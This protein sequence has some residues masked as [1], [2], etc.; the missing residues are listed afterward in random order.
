ML[1]ISNNSIRG[2]VHADRYVSFRMTSSLRIARLFKRFIIIF[3]ILS[4][5]AM[6]MPW[7]QNVQ[8]F[9]KITALR[10]ESRPQTLQS[11]IP[12]RI[13]RWFVREGD[14]VK[15]GD[16]LA[17]IGEVK[18]EY[19]DPNMIARLQEEL[20]S[21]EQ[22]AESYGQKVVAQRQQVTA[23]R[24]NL[25]VKLKQTRLKIKSDSTDVIAAEINFNNSYKQYMRAD[26]LY[27]EGIKS[28]F[29]VEQRLSKY[30]QSNAYLVTAKNKYT[31]SRQELD[32][33][34]ADY[35]EKISKA[36]SEMFSAESARQASLGDVAK[37]RNKIASVETR[38]GY[39]Y[40][41]SPQ[42]AMVTKTIVTGIGENIK[43]GEAIVE[44]LPLDY[45]IA[46]EI[47]VRPVDLPLV[48]IGNQARL[49]FDGWP[50]IVFSGWP[51]TS[52]GT[53]SA[54]VVAVDNVLSSEGGGYRILL[55][56]DDENRA[57]PE[58]LR[59]GSGVRSIMLL[60]DVPVWYELWRQL[61]GFP[62]EYYAAKDISK[63]AK[64]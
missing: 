49:E 61:N 31:Q 13:D 39:Y 16:T 24:Q 29:D 36:E 59:F 20:A 25:V 7:T 42:N 15:Q 63:P 56:S 57:W 46:A 23:L 1:N 53:F 41:T 54:E 40:I 12:G 9:G 5:L 47:F 48:H 18:D 58:Q 2:K 19:F 14:T 43:E 8:G 4:V 10:P 32:A 21:K 52:F 6:F 50:A 38:Q 33:I 64:K 37:L 30:Q 51:N 27:T 22:S 35:S 26:S 34:R 62:P 3:S 28:K 45:R 17:F 55:V 44:L 60:N 11:P